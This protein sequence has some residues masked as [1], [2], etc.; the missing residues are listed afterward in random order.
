MHQLKKNEHHNER[1]IRFFIE[2][3]YPNGTPTVEELIQDNIINGTQLS[4]LAISRTSGIS[5]DDVGIGMDLSDG[6]DVKTTTVGPKP[7]KTWLKIDGVKSDKFNISVRH[8]AVVTK[9]KNKIGTLRIVAYNPFTEGWHFFIVPKKVYTHL[10]Q[11]TITFNKKTGK[12]MGM[13]SQYEVQGWEKF[14]KTECN[15]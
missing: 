7:T 9:V 5:M 15:C 4:E 12:P 13:Y 3:A 6:S 1:L 14:C 10:K 11:V 8:Q 2:K